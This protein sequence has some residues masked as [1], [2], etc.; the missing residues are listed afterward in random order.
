[1]SLQENIVWRLRRPAEFWRQN[2]WC[3]WPPWGQAII[4]YFM[5][6]TF[7]FVRVYKNEGTKFKETVEDY[8]I[9]II[10]ITTF[11]IAL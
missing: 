11:N 10:I 2:Y 8:F 9:M 5:R 1:M 7:Y 4:F 3:Y 6:K